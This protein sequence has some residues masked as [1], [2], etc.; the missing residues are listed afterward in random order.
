MLRPPPF[1]WRQSGSAGG[2]A[3]FGVCM[4][5]ERETSQPVHVPWEVRGVAC[6]WKE[7]EGR[8]PQRGQGGNMTKSGGKG[9][10][11]LAVARAGSR[12]GDE[13][14][15]RGGGLHGA[16]GPSPPL[17]VCAH[18]NERPRRE[19][20]RRAYGAGRRGQGGR[21][22]GVSA[23]DVAG[24]GVGRGRL[25]APGREGEVGRRIMGTHQNKS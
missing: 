11:C 3:G 5:V 6:V 15:K 7:G 8:Q 17:P 18:R 21:R 23:V 25:G 4:Y 13:R 2:E 14:G 16:R 10:R 9:G 1:R 20:G 12:K 19:S 24:R 22:G